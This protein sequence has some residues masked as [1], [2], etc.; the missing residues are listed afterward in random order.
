MQMS[1]SFVMGIINLTDNKTKFCASV[2]MVD[3]K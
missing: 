3:A 2:Y 1:I